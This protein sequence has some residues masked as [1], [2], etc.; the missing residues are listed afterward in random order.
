MV[1]VA[2][3][4]SDAVV[5]VSVA[6][7]SEFGCDG[8]VNRDGMAGISKGCAWCQ[9]AS[10]APGTGDCIPMAMAAL[11]KNGGVLT[12]DTAVCST[13][14][15]SATTSS[16]SN[17]NGNE[18][19]V[20]CS[21]DAV[22][23]CRTQCPNQEFLSCD[24][25]ASAPR[26]PRFVCKDSG[27]APGIVAGIAVAAVF[28]VVCLVGLVY[29][30]AKPADADVVVVD[31][32]GKKVKLPRQLKPAGADGSAML[33]Q[34]SAAAQS[35]NPGPDGLWYCSVSGDPNCNR[36]YMSGEEL[37]T[38]ILKRHPH[39]PITA[40]LSVA[41]PAFSPSPFDVGGGPPPMLG[42]F[43]SATSFPA[44]GTGFSMPA[45]AAQTLAAGATDA[46]AGAIFKCQFPG[47]NRGY[48]LESDLQTHIQ[49]RHT[50]AG[51]IGAS[52]GASFRPQQGTGWDGSSGMF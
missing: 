33:S 51:S 28:F 16:S 35:G 40:P 27:L 10:G 19:T 44:L 5:A 6:A 13:R 45:F 2:L 36:A 4:H 47:C 26:T 39:I 31:K 14:L 38:H 48:Q 21:S 46:G 32:N 20:V 37:N 52:D 7:C 15:N 3:F 29:F 43:Q 30:L 42:Q 49:F 18:P 8:C 23:V 50:G 9:S 34:R 25:L 1:V 12:T 41:N 17:G 24:C 11:C 22:G